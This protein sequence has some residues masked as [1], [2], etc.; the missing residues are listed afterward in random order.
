MSSSYRQ[1]D[2]GASAPL[3]LSSQDR[4]QPQDQDSDEP[5]AEEERTGNEAAGGGHASAATT[6]KRSDEHRSASHDWI[7]HKPHRQQQP[8][9]PMTQGP[10]PVT[11]DDLSA[12]HRFRS[13]SRAPH[14]LAAGRTEDR[15]RTG[16]GGTRRDNGHSTETRS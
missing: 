6:G 12:G 5:R 1:D 13:T 7:R 15:V 14:P 11:D 16:V 3:R 2:R 8:D 10:R 9:D 4:Q